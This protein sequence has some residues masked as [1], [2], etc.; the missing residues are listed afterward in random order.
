MPFKDLNEDDDF[1]CGSIFRKDKTAL[2][3]VDPEEDY[4]EYM[5]FLDGGTPE[6]MICAHI[7]KWEAGTVA[8]HIKMDTSSNRFTVKARE[9]KRSMIMPEEINDWFYI[10]SGYNDQK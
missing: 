8:S 1:F 9:F 3:I 6:Y 2:N 10:K 4:F 7:D 5:L